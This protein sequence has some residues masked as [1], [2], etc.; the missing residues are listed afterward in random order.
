MSLT[1]HTIN[2]REPGLIN[3]AANG[4]DHWRVLLRGISSEVEEDRGNHGRVDQ[5]FTR[6]GQGR[7]AGYVV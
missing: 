6:E 3:S 4:L 1:A 7:E 2:K 5:S